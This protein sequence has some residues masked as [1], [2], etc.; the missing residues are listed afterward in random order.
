MDGEREV[1]DSTQSP[2]TTVGLFAGQGAL[3]VFCPNHA[4]VETRK[5]NVLGK[6]RSYAKCLICGKKNVALMCP[7]LTVN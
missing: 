6:G 1:V 3:C 2:P 7:E 5:R 4:Y